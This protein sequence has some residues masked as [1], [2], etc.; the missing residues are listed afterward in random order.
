MPRLLKHRRK[1]LCKRKNKRN[2][3]HISS[4]NPKNQKISK[5]VNLPQIS[6]AYPDWLKQE[7]MRMTIYMMYVEKCEHAPPMEWGGPEGV[8]SKIHNDL[9]CVRKHQ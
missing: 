3:L 7:T 8:V 1:T 6:S 9:G 4:S 2:S 5:E